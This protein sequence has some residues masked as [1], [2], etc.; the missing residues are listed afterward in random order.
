MGGGGD[1]FVLKKK[2][3]KYLQFKSKFD[4]FHITNVNLML[5]ILEQK[6]F[7]RFESYQNNNQNEMQQQRMTALKEI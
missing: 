2:S 5:Q 1:D 3:K 4:K 6:M 7:L